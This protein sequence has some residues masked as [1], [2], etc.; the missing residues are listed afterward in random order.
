ML[1][2]GAVADAAGVTPRVVR[3]YEQN[4]LLTS[5]RTSGGQRRYSKSAIERVEFIQQLIRAGLTTEIIRNLLSCV[6]TR[7]A[8][9]ET[10]EQLVA[11][12]ERIA[13][14]ADELNSMKRRLDDL[15]VSAER[16]VRGDAVGDTRIRA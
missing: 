1:S 6:N 4:G 11:Q 12:R 9:P 14:R 13:Q 10:L 15:I 5:E 7:V 2:I 8:T 16:T 3:Y